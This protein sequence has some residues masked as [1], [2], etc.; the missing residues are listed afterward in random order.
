[1]HEIVYNKIWYIFLKYKLYKLIINLIFKKKNLIFLH[2]IVIQNGG[3]EKRRTK[4]GAIYIYFIFSL[5]SEKIGFGLTEL[6]RQSVLLTS[7]SKLNPDHE[8]LSRLHKSH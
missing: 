1:M 5:T 4:T 2:K 6:N 3:G 7:M 8:K